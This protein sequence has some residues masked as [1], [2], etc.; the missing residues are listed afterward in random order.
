[1]RAELLVEW[2][3]LKL[4]P[5]GPGTKASPAC[6]TPCAVGNE[7]P[8]GASGSSPASPS[9]ATSTANPSCGL[10][11]HVDCVPDGERRGGGISVDLLVSWCIE[12]RAVFVH[13]SLAVIIGM[14]VRTT[15]LDAAQKSRV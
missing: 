5:A 4:L 2:Q 9:G 8:A 15:T 13:L 12:K 3:I 1:M 7:D 6:R 10:A 11:Y 14:H